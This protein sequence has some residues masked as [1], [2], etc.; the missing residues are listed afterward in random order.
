RRNGRGH[1]AFGQRLSSLGRSFD[2][3]AQPRGRVEANFLDAHGRGP[4]CV[5]RTEGATN[6][7]VFNDQGTRPRVYSACGCRMMAR[8]RMTPSL[9]A[10]WSS[11]PGHRPCVAF[12]DD[13]GWSIYGAERSQPLAI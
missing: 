1:A 13:R 3:V 4:G 8:A 12:T 7:P 6:P 10:R 5:A 2:Q 9:T 11:P